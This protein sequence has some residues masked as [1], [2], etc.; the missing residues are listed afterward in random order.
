MHISFSRL[1]LRANTSG[2]EAGPTYIAAGRSPAL[3]PLVSVGV[4]QLSEVGK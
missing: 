4:P 3:G 1:L 2:S